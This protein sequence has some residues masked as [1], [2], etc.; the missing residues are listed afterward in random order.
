MSAAQE[1]LDSV[2]F[3]YERVTARLLEEF[4]SF[5]KQKLSDM[6]EIILNFLSLQVL[7]SYL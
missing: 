1:V 2:K 4:D 7:F 6:K 3:D 5:G